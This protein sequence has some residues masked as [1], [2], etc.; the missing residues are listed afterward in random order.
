MVSEDSKWY[1]LSGFSN[2]LDR[3][4]LLFVDPFPDNRVCNACGLVPKTTAFLPCRHVMC[5][6]C[7]D[8]CV[9]SGGV[10]AL[11]GDACPDKD[12]R[13]RDYPVEH[14]TKRQVACWNREN[15]CE[16]VMAV[17]EISEH[18]QSD[19]AFHPACCHKCDSTVLQSDV[20][21]HIKSQCREKV[22]SRPLRKAADDAAASRPLAGTD[23]VVHEVRAALQKVS[24]QNA[25]LEARL[26]QLVVKDK[27]LVAVQDELKRVTEALN[28]TQEEVSE[29]NRQKDAQAEELA[30][31]K[32]MI[33]VFTG[34][35]VLA[36]QENLSNKA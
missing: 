11:D 18:F 29:C 24:E 25:S 23:S 20:I 28:R 2:E 17:S 21:A 3:R 19:C 36:I 33:D 34:E 9:L 13:W 16:A 22:L 35:I 26:S 7:Y 10:C 31:L 1:T 8:N 6:P 30:S 27:E 14:V 32:E 4:P 5:K 15:G 12:A